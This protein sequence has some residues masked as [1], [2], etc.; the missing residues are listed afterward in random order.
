MATLSGRKF[1][2]VQTLVQTAPDKAVSML[3]RALAEAGDEGPLGS[4]RRLVE[5]EIADRRLRGLVLQSVAPLFGDRGDGATPG[6]PPRALGLLWRALKADAA[7]E[8]ARAARAADE[9]EGE[10]KGG[11]DGGRDLRAAIEGLLTLAAGGVRGRTSPEFEAV[12]T[13]CDVARPDGAEALARYLDLAPVASRAIARLAE[14]IAHPGGDTAA[15]ARVAHRDAVD[16]A[17]D[18]GPRFFHMLAAHL[19][20]RWMVMRII[21]AVMDKP[22]ERYLADSELADFGEGVLGDVDRLL[23]KLATLDLASGAQAGC[24]AAQQLESAVQQIVE[25]ESSVELTRE[26]GWGK[27][28]V[29]QRTAIAGM[30]AGRLREA[31]TAVQA[32]LP[33]QQARGARGRGAVNLTAAPNPT[34]L[35]KATALLAFAEGSRSS[36]NPGGFTAVRGKAMERLGEW[37]NQYADEA[38]EMLRHD[39]PADLASARAVLAA[40]ADLTGFVQGEKAAELIRRRAAVSV[41]PNDPEGL[42]AATG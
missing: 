35:A 19:P 30:V 5:A 23:G 16:L 29:G 21:S 12:S 33:N 28:I 22:T 31:E 40:V 10:T 26:H 9:A 18:A 41:Q 36:M 3:E 38:L 8:I 14:W 6:F 13:A 7:G 39:R 34:A 11:V 20:H 42:I 4:V 32:A 24:A 1:E 2:I 27:R 17:D 25:V 37:L 15:A